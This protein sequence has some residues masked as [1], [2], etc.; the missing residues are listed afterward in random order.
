MRK[1]VWQIP[2]Q[3]LGYP[4]WGSGL[5]QQFWFLVITDICWKPR[6]RNWAAPGWENWPAHIS[7]SPISAT[8]LKSLWLA[9]QWHPLPGDSSCHIGAY[10]PP[11]LSLSLKFLPK[12]LIDFLKLTKV[13]FLRF[14]RRQEAYS[15]WS[16]SFLAGKFSRN[17]P[18]FWH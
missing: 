18:I 16:E 4:C 6:D 1:I 2:K 15:H 14:L 12:N 7:P 8:S 10:P 17:S 5:P 9:V 13:S 11:R 3:Q